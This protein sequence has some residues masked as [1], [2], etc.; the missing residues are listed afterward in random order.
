MK[1]LLILALT[2]VLMFSQTT[3]FTH[4]R[5]TENGKTYSQGRSAMVMACLTAKSEG[6][7]AADGQMSAMLCAGYIEGIADLLSE[8]DV[9]IA[10]EVEAKQLTQVFLQYASKHQTLLHGPASPLVAAALRESYPCRKAT[11]KR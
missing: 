11:T 5:F 3:D 7:S 6:L 8:T 9:C 1:P 10:P 4:N 2:S